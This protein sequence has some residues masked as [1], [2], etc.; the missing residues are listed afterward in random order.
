MSLPE[1]TISIKINGI[2]EF[3]GLKMTDEVCLEEEK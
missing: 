2:D 3:F 1:N